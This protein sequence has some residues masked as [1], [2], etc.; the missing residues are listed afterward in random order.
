MYCVVKNGIT[1][2][3]HESAELASAVL[4][5][6]R[7]AEPLADISMGIVRESASADKDNAGVTSAN[8][9]TT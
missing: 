6:I 2:S 4:F 8:S 7:A 3:V 9:P 1:I 5:Q